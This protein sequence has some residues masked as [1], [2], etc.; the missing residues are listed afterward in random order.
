MAVL[1]VE[2]LTKDFGHGRGV[3]DVNF[4]IEKGE[5]F[6]FLGPNGA[7]KSTTIRHLMGFTK[8]DEGK[9]IIN[10]FDCTKDYDKVMKHVGYLPG[11][12][13][14]PEGLTGHQFL[15]MMQK[16]RGVKNDDYL[17]YLLKFFE[18]D[19]SGNTKR[20]SLGDKRKLAVVAAFA[21][22][23]EILILDEPTSGL[24]PLMQEKFIQFMV[25]EKHR[26]KTILLSSHIFPEVEATCDRIAIIKEGRV[27]AEVDA[28]E[29]KSTD[30]KS[31]QLMFRNHNDLQEALDCI[32]NAKKG[33]G[34]SVN[35]D[36]LQRE[37]TNFFSIVRT[38]K[39]IM[40][41][42]ERFDLESYFLDFYRS[43]RKFA[44]L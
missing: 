16:L 41:N 13:A 12:I 38:L 33:K 39:P 24:D 20:M 30:K 17:N 34:L 27:V 3:F 22:D 40:I 19:P 15:R 18:F 31:Y 14:L 4:E 28:N 37:L 35:V 42:E 36:V 29:L 6:G 21:S 5:V 9:V 2:R 11:E 7:G 26:G 10:G 23:P 32:P 25:K 43:D 44:T 1:K 8:P